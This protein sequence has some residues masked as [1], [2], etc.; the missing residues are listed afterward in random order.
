MAV[1]PFGRMNPGPNGPYV[2]GEAVTPADTTVFDTPMRGLW[3]GGAGTLR[4]TLRDQ[5]AGVALNL[6]AV[7]A[8]VFLP[9]WVTRVHATGT[10]CT[11]IV[12]FR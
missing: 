10:T 8:G 7:P 2:Y 4:V 5:P 9:L 12:A 3:I 11:G 1:D 6:A